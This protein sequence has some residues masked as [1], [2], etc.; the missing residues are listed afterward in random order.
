MNQRSEEMVE[1]N[2]PT[3]AFWRRKRH[4]ACQAQEALLSV[5]WTDWSND[6]IGKWDGERMRRKGGG[7]RGREK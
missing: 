4:K 7:R 1:S 5:R 3:R 2:H 6:P